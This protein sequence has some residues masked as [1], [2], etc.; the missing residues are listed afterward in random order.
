MPADSYWDAVKKLKVHKW[1]GVTPGV[2][3]AVV[4]QLMDKLPVGERS[5]EVRCMLWCT[6]IAEAPMGWRAALVSVAP[7]R[8][9]STIGK[10][11]R[12]SAAS[13]KVLEKNGV[14]Y[15]CRE[16]A[17]RIKFVDPREFREVASL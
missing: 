5:E 13:F 10:F 12:G 3:K 8:L 17:A 4:G 9:R 1:K 14:L 16:S 7:E 2:Y 6:L 15:V 11:V